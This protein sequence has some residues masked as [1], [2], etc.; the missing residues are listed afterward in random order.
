[1]IQTVKKWIINI[2]LNLDKPNDLVRFYIHD[3]H[4]QNVLRKLSDLS[5]DGKIERIS[6][7]LDTSGETLGT[8]QS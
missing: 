1:M 6:I 5:F 8:K 2:N 4:Y 7:A 3:N